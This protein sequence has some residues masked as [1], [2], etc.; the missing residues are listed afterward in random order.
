VAGL[1][2]NSLSIAVLQRDRDKPNTTN[3]LLQTLAAVDM[4]Y[5][6]AS[7]VIQPLK[8]IYD[9][10]DWAAAAAAATAV[11]SNG[12]GD[13]TEAIPGRSGSS[14]TSVS[15]FRIVYPYIEA[16]AWVIASI[17]QTTTVWLVML[18]TI[19]RYVAVC[20]PMKVNTH[21]SVQGDV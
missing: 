19:D 6:L 8:T 13:V 4:V 3:W 15:W 12:G 14:D 2:G 10:G 20:L 7:G 21:G 11:A 1:I 5:L 16:H 17:A 9:M 18:V